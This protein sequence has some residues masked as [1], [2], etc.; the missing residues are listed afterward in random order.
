MHRAAV[1]A[2]VIVL[3]VIAALACGSPVA[4]PDTQATVNAA[5]AATGTAQAG[6]QATIDA[7]VKATRVAAPTP[8]PSATYVAMTAD[9]LAA[10]IDQA[11]TTAITSTQQ[12]VTATTQA[13]ADGTI[14]P[15]EAQTVEVYVTSADAAIAYAE[16]LIYAYYGLYGELA[17]ETL[18]VLEAIESDLYLMDESLAAIDAAL[19][20]AIQQGTE[21]AGAA[22]NQ[23]KT[24]AQVANAKAT[25]AQ[26]RAQGWTQKL[27]AELEKRTAAMLAVQPNKVAADRQAALQSAFD[28]VDAVRKALA[29][30]KIGKSE[31]AN[32]AQL[33]ANAAASLNAQGGQ[34]QRLSGLVNNV[35]GQ[36]ASGQVPQ[37]KAELGKLEASLGA[38]PS[39]PSR[40]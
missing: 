35:T 36:L 29:D 28:Y 11:V 25:D 22:V 30:N 21:L 12:C 32:I 10:V 16:E 27:H 37:A 18:A 19:S 33:G 26:T 4:T 34:L 5:I 17:A 2:F 31:M 14:T 3:L 15:Q 23:L 9:E 1:L 7:A 20:K 6:I 38:R 40:P 13:A 24:A 39:L 8:T